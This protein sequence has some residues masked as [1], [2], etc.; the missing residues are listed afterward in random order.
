MFLSSLSFQLPTSSLTDERWRLLRQTQQQRCLT[1]RNGLESLPSSQSAS[2]ACCSLSSLRAHIAPLRRFVRWDLMRS[3]TKTVAIDDDAAEGRTRD[4]RPKR[5]PEAVKEVA[6]EAA[7]AVEGAELPTAAEASTSTPLEHAPPSDPEQAPPAKKVRLSG[8]QKKAAAR[9]RSEI[10]WQAKKA[11]KE[12]KAAAKAAGIEV[13]G[14]EEST[15][16]GGRKKGKGQNKVRLLLS[17]CWRR[18]KLMNVG[19]CR[20]ASLTTELESTLS[21]SAFLLPAERTA[22]D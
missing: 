10:A 17:S 2:S 5:A 1:G 19:S 22:R 12:A 15:E 4:D 20:A 9:E 3:G 18:E 6:N 8:A 14:V 11:D 7:A 13:E 16:G 21:S